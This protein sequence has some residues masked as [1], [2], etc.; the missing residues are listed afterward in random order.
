[1]KCCVFMVWKKVRLG[2]RVGKNGCLCLRMRPEGW[3]CLGGEHGTLRMGILRRRKAPNEGPRVRTKVLGDGLR[4][5][6]P[7]IVRRTMNCT[8]SK[9]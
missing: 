9:M 4:G 7:L 5:E 1:M 2:K 8:S 3:T 6:I